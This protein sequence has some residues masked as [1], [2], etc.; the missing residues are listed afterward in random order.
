MRKFLR[1]TRLLFVSRV[2]RTLRN[3]VWAMIG[4][5]QP[6]LYLLLFAPLLDGL[7]IPGFSQT[8]SLNLFVPGLV[9]MLALFGAS[10]SGFGIME[11]LRSGVLERLRVT[12]AN[13]LSLLLGMVLHDV[14]VFLTQCAV[15]VV[16]AAIMGM[17]VNM[18]GIVTLFGLLVLLGMLMV[19]VSY[20]LT[21]ILK[22]EGALAAILSTIT[23][24]LLL[25]S[26]VLLPLTLA[27]RLLQTLAELNPLSHTVSAARALVSGQ[28]GDQN[29]LLAFGIIAVLVALASIWATR[30]F[31]QATA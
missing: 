9:I 4:L 3:P 16:V 28:F 8:S 18:L 13:R 7:R 6:V 27:P 21:L 5:L 23:Q 29:I 30:I 22:D 10:F 19:F 15:L 2:K 12:P 31:R 25:L 20:A 17:Q 24:P 11:D 1:E 26:G 14:L